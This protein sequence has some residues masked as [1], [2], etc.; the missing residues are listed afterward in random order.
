MCEMEAQLATYGYARVSTDGQ[1]LDAQLG[2]L[3]GAG[4][5]K[6]FRE[7]ISGARADRPELAKLLKLLDAGDVVIVTRLDRLARS[8]RSGSCIGSVS[9]ISPSSVRPY[10]VPSDRIRG[11]KATSGGQLCRR[12]NNAS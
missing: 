8:T 3:K 12:L 9:G 7:K 4:C 1:S 5:T 10:K 11:G 6:I 2:Q